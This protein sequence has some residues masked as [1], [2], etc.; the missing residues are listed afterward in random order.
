MSLVK[1]AWPGLLP[2]QLRKN[3]FLLDQLLGR[4]GQS[5]Q[6]SHSDSS[7]LCLVEKASL[8]NL[9]SGAGF[10]G[11]LVQQLACFVL[12]EEGQWWS[13]FYC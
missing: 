3:L 1:A 8:W 10:Q 2:V 12:F 7:A 11:T 6:S 9:S 5:P 13:C 4:F